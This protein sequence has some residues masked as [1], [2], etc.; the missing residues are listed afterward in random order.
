MFEAFMGFV[1]FLGI[2]LYLVWGFLLGPML[3]ITG[4][5]D[6]MAEEKKS[7]PV[8]SKIKGHIVPTHSEYDSKY[9]L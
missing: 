5:L 1:V 3:F 6:Y 7:K 8:E 2:I 9:E 4:K